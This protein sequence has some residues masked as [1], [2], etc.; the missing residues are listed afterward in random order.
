M[1]YHIRPKQKA[2]PEFEHQ[3]IAVKHIE[4][5]PDDGSWDEKEITPELIARI[6]E[7]IPHGC[8]LFLSLDP[9]GETDFMEV[10]SDGK[11]LSLGC[12]FD[13][14]TDYL[15]CY[16]YN[17]DFAHTYELI[18][19]M[20]FKDKSVWSSLV[21]GGQSPVPLVHTMTDME[22]GLKAVAY[23]IATGKLYP[24]MDWVEEV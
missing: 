1:E 24:G 5:Y 15:N 20:D 18:D 16:S 17:S 21:S 22:L 4:Y 23:F 7:D 13:A 11:I 3:A 10:M 6:L 19:K 2:V 9:Y 12:M 8:D 14:E